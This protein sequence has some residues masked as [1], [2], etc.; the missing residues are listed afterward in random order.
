MLD[1]L[2]QG[3]LPIETE[4]A[5]IGGA[6]YDAARRIRCPRRRSRSR[7]PPT[8]CCSAPSAG[9]EVRHAAARAAARAGHPRHPQGARRCSRTCAR[10]CCY[11]ELAAASTLKPDV[12][13][14]LDIMIIR[15]LTGD[16]YFG[17][18]R[19]RA[20]PTATGEREGFDTMRYADREIERI[21]RVG[22]ETAR[23]R[24]ASWLTSVDKAN[25]LDTSHA[26]ARSRDRGRTR[27]SR[28]RARRTCTSTTRRCSWCARR[29][30]STSSS[31]ATCSATSCPTRRRCS[32]A[33]SACCRRRRST[34]TAR[35]STSRSTA[36]RPTS[37]AR[38]SRESA[39][40]D[41]VASR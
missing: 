18:P 37:R 16:I 1:V 13:A 10:R 35:A 12:V 30:R 26:V 23:K 8:P 14:G 21:A 25:V 38:T 6:G 9:R 22:F 3:G 40:D 20:A 29:R 17:E 5:P 41:P 27:L 7:R 39:G 32:P 31:P 15:E 24:A 33:R 19:G 2:R 4:A 28:R 34:R 11:P 36:R